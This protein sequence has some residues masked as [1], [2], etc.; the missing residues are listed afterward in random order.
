MHRMLRALHKLCC[1][2]LLLSLLT[3]GVAEEVPA[4]KESDARDQLV[5][6]CL[7]RLGGRERL[8]FTF[9]APY[10]L[11]AENGSMLYFHAGSQVTLQVEDDLIY[12]YYQE[13]G[14]QLGTHVSLERSNDSEDDA[15]GFR[16]TNFPALYM[17]DL[18]LD[19][20]DGNFRS[21]L[22]IHVEDYL[23]GVVP[24]EMGEDFPLEAL[25][26]QAIAART[27]A[28]RRQGQYR[29]YDILDNTNDQVF[30]GYIA[31][32]KRSEKAVQETRGI[33]G[34]YKGELAQC[35][36]SASNGGQTELVQTVWGGR[37]PYAYYNAGKDPYDVA[38]PQ[39][40]VR[41]F[42]LYKEY[43][44][45]KEAPDVLRQIIAEKLAE[46][47]KDQGHQV[48]QDN[49]R[50]DAVKA[51]QV[52]MPSASDSLH[53]TNLHM[54]LDISLRTKPEFAIRAI[55][56][57]PE[58]VHLFEDTPAETSELANDFSAT[59]PEATYIPFTPLSETISVDIPIFP[60]AEE[61]FSL[62]ISANYQ[63][64][65]WSVVEKEKEFLIEVRRYGHGVG[66]SQRGAQWMASEYDKTYQEILSFYYPGMGLIRF[67]EQERKFTDSED[68]LAATAGPAP[69]P[70]PRPTPM[71]ISL[72]PDD[73]Q[74]YAAVT[75]IADDS[76]L[77]LRAQPSMNSDVLM[78]L[79]KGQRLLV[80]E[81]CQEEGWVHVRTDDAD[82]YVMEKY[83][84][85]EKQ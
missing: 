1:I 13:M 30:R 59:V 10:Q 32:Y 64:E 2:L 37:E 14:Q 83:L 19:V 65:I 85:K 51:V 3:I 47:L 29:D 7:T 15:T 69:S 77:N 79:Y 61:A 53:M 68:A 39:S 66:M 44:D 38:N 21:V 76:S 70:T 49:V 5:R 54:E 40:V 52:S 75:E 72:I 50:I 74:W 73:G 84:T 11:I 17:G 16:L 28:L 26:A 12:L 24:Y 18:K 25:K 82:G 45:E 31:G 4:I 41:T 78:R 56:T 62:N 48:S 27:Y 20:I 34:Y 43:S 55:D 81:R 33:C 60:D 58:E 57:S 80:A 63:N 36:Y 46:A 42:R 35:Y 23:L 71:P 6:V 8:D 22:S 9:T 67:P